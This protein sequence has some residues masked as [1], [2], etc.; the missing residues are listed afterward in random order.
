[1]LAVHECTLPCRWSVRLRIIF[2]TIIATV[3]DILV[4]QILGSLSFNW[5]EAYEGFQHSHKAKWLSRRVVPI[6]IRRWSALKGIPRCPCTVTCS[7]N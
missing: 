5:I 1:M 2:S 3:L 7:S 4:A 6:Y